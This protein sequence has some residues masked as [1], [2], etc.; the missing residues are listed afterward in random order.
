MTV[1]WH[2]IFQRDNNANDG[3]PMTS[4]CPIIPG[5]SYTYKFNV[6]QP[7]TYWYHSK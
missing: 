5:T 7:G 1:H 2:G 4:Q 3:T 6:D